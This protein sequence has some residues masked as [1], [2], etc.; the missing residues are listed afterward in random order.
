M[1]LSDRHE[2]RPP[3]AL[4]WIVFTAALIVFGRILPA[5]F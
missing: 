4:P 3:R 2:A 1:Q 5:F